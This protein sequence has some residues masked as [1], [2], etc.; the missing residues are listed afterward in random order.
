[1]PIKPSLAS[2]NV[3]GAF[4]TEASLGSIPAVLNTHDT[5]YVLGSSVQVGAPVNIPTYISNQTDFTN[6]F[7]ASPSAAAID[8]FFNQR[9]GYGLFFVNVG[10][11]VDQT[12]TVTV[13]ALGTVLTATIDGYAINYTCVTGDTATTARDALGN[14]INT[15][16]PNT[17]SYYPDGTLRYTSGLVV[18]ASANI[19]LGSATTITTVKAKDVADSLK[20]AFQPEMRQG[21]LCAPEF[22]QSFTAL[23]DRTFLQAQMEAL[24]SNPSYYWVSVVDCGATT[25]TQ[26]TG[27][28]AINAAIAERNTFISPRGNSWY[29]FPYLKNI[30]GTLIPS[31]LAVIGVALRRARSEGFAQPPA[32]VTYPIYGVSDVSFKVTST[33]QSQMNPVGINCIRN[34]PAGRGIV[35]YGA[36]TLSTSSFYRFGSVRIILNV[37]AGS[38]KIAFDSLIFSLVDGQGALFSRV[39]QTAA[40]YC[41]RLRLGGALYGA[42]PADAYLCIADLTNNTM[43]GLESGQ[44]NLDVIVRPSPTMEVLNITLSRASLGTVLAEI[45]SAGDTSAVAK[46]TAS[47][48]PTA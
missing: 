13:F 2:F 4:V 9:S 31:S 43:D 41:E 44:V 14:L 34:L 27:G 40:A 21:Y 3:P 6:V 45:A 33:I 19:T 17:A 7:G 8:L 37:L 10:M 30:T 25:A 15:Q 16:L 28:G 23:S 39:K 38:L 47:L 20:I 12:L 42:S 5:V 11:R 32:G 26:T 1:M 24:V 29:Y 36:R 18:T 46:P 48:T 35:V 22:F